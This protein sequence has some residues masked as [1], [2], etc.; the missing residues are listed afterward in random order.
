MAGLLEAEQR[1]QAFIAFLAASRGLLIATWCL[2][3]AA[4]PE[5][6]Q[7]F[8]SKQAQRGFGFA[9]TAAG[10]FSAEASSDRADSAALTNTVTGIEDR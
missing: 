3:Q 6:E 9:A 5:A 2:T 10:L 1:Y 7:E 4:T 8:W